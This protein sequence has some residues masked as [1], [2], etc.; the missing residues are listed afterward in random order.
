MTIKPRRP[1]PPRPATAAKAKPAAKPATKP[2]ASP[3]ASPVPVPTAAPT[4]YLS[5]TLAA[6]VTPKPEPT[7]PP[8]SITIA[9]LPPPSTD[10]LPTYSERHGI[11]PREMRGV[12]LE[13]DPSPASDLAL[14][15]VAPI[16]SERLTLRDVFGL[17]T[18]A[19]VALER[20]SLSDPA[21][22]ALR[23]SGGWENITLPGFD[24]VPSFNAVEDAIWLTFHGCADLAAACRALGA[25]WFRARHIPVPSFLSA[26][27]A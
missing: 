17:T 22:D 26:P 3:P 6:P 9:P 1:S 18:Y 7:L 12:P 10:P 8:I 24:Y 16:S 4:E 13:T 20:F 19:A 2:P 5:D 21:K 23:K 15:S 25:E 11:A 14:P 27:N